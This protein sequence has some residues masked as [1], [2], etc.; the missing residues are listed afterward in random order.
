MRYRT[1]AGT[2]VG[3]VVLAV[4]G[5][6][7][8][9]Q[10]APVPLTDPLTVQTQSTA[11]TDA[12]ALG[13]YAVRSSV[14]TVRLDG[15]DVEAR[16]LMPVGVDGDVPAVVFVHGAGTGKFED[17]FVDQARS[18]AEA[19]VATLV[20]NKRLDTYTLRHRDYVAMADDYLRSW[21]L[22]RGL[23]GIDPDRVGVYAESE[24]AWIAPVMAADQPG[25]GFVVLASAPV[26]PPRQ[27]AAFAVDSY[28]R[29]TG[30]P[31]QVFRAIPRAVGMSL[32]GGGL[33][34]ADF[35]VAPYQRRMSQPVLVVYG[36][37][38]ASMP[39][40]QGA[41]QIIRDLAIAANTDYTVRY[42]RGADHGIR[43]DEVVA[44]AFLD[45]LAGWV[46]GLPA[47]ASAAPADRGP[48]ARAAV[49][50]RSGAAA[51]VAGRRRR[52]AVPRRGGG[53][54]A[55]AAARRA[56]RRGG[57][58]AGAR[59]RAGAGARP[60]ADP[61]AGA[62]V[63][64]I[65]RH[66]RRAG[67]VPR[68]GGPTRRRVRAQRL[69]R[70]GRLDRGARAR[71]GRRVRRGGRR[72]AAAAAAPGPASRWRTGCSGTSC[73]GAPARPARPCW[74]SWR[75]GAC[76]SSA[77]EGVDDAVRGAATRHHGACQ[78]DE[79][80]AR[81]RTTWGSATDRGRVR[82][83]N[84]DALLAHPPV[85]L[86]ADGMGGH[87]AGD[88]ASRLAVEEFGALAGRTAVD[89]SD[90]HACFRS[91]ARRI[92]GAFERREG[93]TTVAGVALGEH[94]GAAHWLVFNVGDSRV[95]RWADGELAQLT[96][97]HSVVQEL[98]D[99]GALS[100][101]AAEQHPERHVLTRA[102]GTRCRPGARLLDA[103]RAP[104][105]PPAGVL[106]RRDRRARAVRPGRR[107]GPRPGRRRGRRRARPPRGRGGRP[108]QRHGRRRGRPG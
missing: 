46:Q 76:T 84:E 36:T 57:R 68:L 75:T 93:G 28:L 94:D 65:R 6:L 88:V 74:W 73:C 22:L 4:L 47:T 23:P 14:L 2:V 60:R 54:G 78:G 87:E 30:V 91:A 69:D 86:V 48:A 33:D 49:L 82:A 15:A 5:A 3:A 71:P 20:P 19:G 62:A 95:Y 13:T 32:P 43:V 29:N 99:S 41:E 1:A 104:R 55:R 67:L 53:G 107:A 85:F 64:G 77:S 10:W 92:R 8:G 12:P 40:V 51:A 50:G 100:R 16:L 66:G 7:M 103:A 25:I 97:D 21:D 27:Q 83:L 52:A 105:R 18:L 106:R 44:P 11:I 58:P 24:G 72:G 63:R 89:P 79:G 61:A 26:V 56:A 101:D 17:A 96:V 34:Y 70:P 45:D 80:R 39:V 59:P 81:V 108:G 9:P 31:Q 102:L 98:V 38:D 42:Y 90:L 35:D 37:A